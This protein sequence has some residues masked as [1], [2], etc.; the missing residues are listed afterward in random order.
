[1]TGLPSEPPPL[2]R[3]WLDRAAHRRTD[4]Q[5]QREAWLKARVLV[6]D[7]GR[8]LIK[9][10]ALVLLDAAQAPDGER[11][12]LGVDDDGT[13]YFAVAAETPEV[14]GAQ[15]KDLRQIG[16][17]LGERDAALFIT[18][19]SLANWH[20]R[21][22]Y[23][24]LSG[25][26][27]RL[28]DA[29]WT[30]VTE[31]GEE[32]LW[33]RTDPAVI[34]LVHDGVAGPEGRCLLGHNSSWTAPEWEDRYSCLAGFVEPGESAE[35]TVEREVREEVGIE[36]RDI[37]Y[38]ASQPWPFPGSIMVGFM[39]VADP[40]AELHL[41]PVE[42]SHARWFTRAEIGE[43]LAGQPASFGLPSAVSIARYLVSRWHS[44]QW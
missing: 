7:E 4:Q 26:P 22:P 5:W 12:F 2:A 27:T 6:I 38:V 25:R 41:D 18:A 21:H 11:Y 23:S 28:G 30:R 10:N 44:E 40:D 35:A 33:P 20:A 39:A 14:P 43:V 1:V 8:T 3:G 13:P 19:A 9:D 29:G 34:M 31:D 36:V 32:V 17:R 15:R 24:P 42:I 37:R 16:D